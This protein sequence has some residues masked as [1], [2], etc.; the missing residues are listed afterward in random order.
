[1]NIKLGLLFSAFAVVL[2]AGV[3]ANVPV[4]AQGSQDWERMPGA[5]MEVAIGGGAVWAIGT[6]SSQSGGH[7]IY[8]WEGG[9]WKVYPGAGVRIAV[10][11]SG[12]PWVVN[13][14]H[15]IYRWSGG[16][17]GQWSKL[18]GSA[19]DIGA[20]GGAVWVLGTN[21]V[22]GG[23]GVWRWNGSDWSSVDGAAVHIAVDSKGHPWVVNSSHTIFS[24]QPSTATWKA[25]S[26]S[27]T[28]I[29]A[30]S[31]V[32]VTGTD[33]ASGGFGIWKLEDST[34]HKH[35][36]GGVSIAVG[37]GDR[38]WVVNDAHEIYRRNI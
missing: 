24:Y 13:S 34:W 4:R 20:G 3:A 17:G 2:A 15:E 28:S 6:D 35:S 31:T 19:T 9:N 5:A 37:P 29:G 33:E 23:Y 22:D 11:S 27:A 38:P 1:M 25:M 30:G 7:N 10:D 8:K 14:N 26:G 18:P 12:S 16:A 32:W 36:G 21:A